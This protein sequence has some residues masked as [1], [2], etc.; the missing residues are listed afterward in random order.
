[1][2]IDRKNIEHWAEATH[3]DLHLPYLI[4][5][6]INSTAPIGALIRIPCGT[7]TSLPGWDGIVESEEA[8]SFIPQGTSLWEFGT[9]QDIKG[10]ADDDYDKRTNDPLGYDPSQ[11]TYI[12]VTPRVWSQKDKWLTAKKEEKKWKDIRVYDSVDLAL[13]LD[14]ATA[15]ARW[16][17]AHIDMLPFDGILT[18][19]QFWEEWSAGPIKLTPKIVTAGREK[20]MEILS[21]FLNDVPNIKAV[22]AKT[23]TEAIAFIIATAKQLPA[24]LHDLFFAKTLLMDT[25]GHY[26]ALHSNSNKTPLNLIPKFEDA[27][28]LYAAVSSGH[29]VIVPLGG[30]DTFN[31]GFITL[32]TIAKEGQVEGLMQMGLSREDAERHSREAGRDIA[33]LRRLLK[34]PQNTADWFK[35]EKLRDIIPALLLGRWNINNSGDREILEKLSG[36]PF[37][38]YME[39]LMKWKDFADS[40]LLQIGA[41]WRLTS[42]LDLWDS[43]SATV[44]ENDFKLLSESFLQVYQQLEEQDD[45][46]SGPVQII[47]SH[48][49]PKKYSSWAHEGLAQSLIL[50]SQFDGRSKLTNLQNSSIWV[51]ALVEKL[52][53]N[54]SDRH[55][56]KWDQKL[57]L[58]SE[59]SP[60][61]FLSAVTASLLSE[62]KPIMAMFASKKSFMGDSSN[63]T[64][65][66]WALEGLA[67]LA[68]YLFEATKIL[69]KLSELDPGG[70]LVYRPSNSL[71]EIY[72]SWHFQTLA[73][74]D[75]RME[76][77]KIAVSQHKKEGWKLLRRL[78][79]EHHGTAS[80]TFKMRWRLFDKNIN[81][82]YT[83]AEI[84]E[85]YS[86]V[87]DM[88]LELFDNSDKKLA[89]IINNS[90]TAI[91]KEDREKMLSFIEANFSKI[92]PRSTQSRDQLRKILNH[93]RSYPDAEWSLPEDTLLRYQAI[94]DAMEPDDV[95][96]K[97][98]W[99]FESIHVTFPDVEINEVG[100]KYDYKKQYER[101][102]AARIE[103]LETILKSIDLEKI[104]DLAATRDSSITIGQ[105][106]ALMIK[107]QAGIKTIFHLLKKENPNLI[108]VHRFAE[109]KASKDGLDW[110]FELFAQ[111]KQEGFDDNM[112]V[113][114][115]LPLQQGK[116][117]W[118]FVK[119][120]GENIELN[121]WLA[122]DP[123]FYHI[124]VEEKIVGIK[125]LLLY[126]RYFIA[127]NLASMITEDLPTHVLAEILQLAATEKSSK[128]EYLREYDVTSIFKN[129]E[130]RE[131]MNHEELAK[132]EWLY[133]S[134]L[135]S[136]GSAYKPKQLHQELAKSPDFFMQILKW[137]YHPKD[138]KRREAEKKEI[139]P[140][141]HQKFARQAYHLLT[142]FKTIPGIQEDGSIDG[143]YLNE[144]VD[145]IRELAK[146]ADRAEMADSVI[147]KL[148]AYYTEANQDYW[149]ADEISSIIE[150][151]NTKSIKSSFSMTVTNKRGST[152]RS[153]FEGGNIERANAA[154]FQM[155][156]EVHRY[157]HVNL[158]DIFAKIAA[159]YLVDAKYE[160]EQAE[161]D[162]LEY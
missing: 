82:A 22:K 2:K 145:R 56:I 159:G 157:K 8:R 127:V 129:L 158:S 59:A 12:F 21:A 33:H 25:D 96:S 62:D 40:P 97:Y 65:L 24:E 1:M 53:E 68:E 92:P 70:N 132:L 119:Q 108:L 111:L 48:T 76:I 30:D 41:T 144:W 161:R 60:K 142:D 66:L 26:R 88:L 15:V 136:Y 52:L 34:F 37:E 54:A 49:K 91:K 44:N 110:A 36:M 57:P 98:W 143:D 67:W 42:P 114:L 20:E 5:K 47:T 131:D 94:Y 135:S 141:E 90:T 93:H 86:A 11:C 162:K 7:G 152:A 17:A 106:L 10:K 107:D 4:S 78:M 160:D 118:D 151:I 27:T 6:L 83:Y 117:L 19:D 99:L 14:N 121:Y 148:L 55:W 115:L 122:V 147:G 9:N 79:P 31:L 112:L 51:D 32:P 3:S 45:N 35:N 89:Q 149:P 46:N 102:Q 80:P 74:F 134:I 63:H 103:A 13:W 109:I 43:L 113:Q 138:E 124:A 125:K 133:L 95:I 146:E 84:Y 126:K 150:R 139:D 128:D 123:H 154:H 104:I 69:L 130:T 100:E 28:P 72:K 71:A 39:I 116:E 155:L 85:T 105:S 77:L 120:A 153:P 87:T 75:Q 64:G 23:K 38:D 16:F 29:H 73:P 156:A 61:S 137:A 50:I 58:I 18:A 101:V 81:L 140:E